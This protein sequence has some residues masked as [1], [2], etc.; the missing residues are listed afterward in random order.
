MDCFSTFELEVLIDQFTWIPSPDQT[1]I[2]PEMRWINARTVLP[3][4]TTIGTTTLRRITPANP[5]T[6]NQYLI[7]RC[8]IAEDYLTAKRMVFYETEQALD[9]LSIVSQRGF[10]LLKITP[11]QPNASPKSQKKINLSDRLIAWSNKQLKSEPTQPT[12]IN[13]FITDNNGQTTMNL[14]P[15]MEYTVEIKEAGRLQEYVTFTHDAQPNQLSKIHY[16]NMT[17]NDIVMSTSEANTNYLRISSLGNVTTALRFYRTLLQLNDYITRYVLLWTA[18]ESACGVPQRCNR[19]DKKKTMIE[20]IIKLP[21]VKTNV[22]ADELFENLY[23]KRNEIVHNPQITRQEDFKE[24]LPEF[25]SKLEWLCVNSL[26]D[27]LCLM[28]LHENASP[29]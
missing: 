19:K 26:L 18:L 25:Y 28:M 5:F 15:S 20:E 12:P 29:L 7:K 11:P 27:K 16:F 10:K 2:I 23:D 3:D 24:S 17:T 22:K 14:Q 9:I 8:V 4:P 21:S 1:A 6:K 13:Q